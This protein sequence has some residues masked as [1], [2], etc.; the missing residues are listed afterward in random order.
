MNLLL[1]YQKFNH[2][3]ITVC[4]TSDLLMELHSITII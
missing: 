2:A 3:S 1:V 4:A